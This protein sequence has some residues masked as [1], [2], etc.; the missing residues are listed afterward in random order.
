MVSLVAEITGYEGTKIVHAGG[1][2]LKLTA[3]DHDAP[4][5]YPA[6]TVI[7]IMINNDGETVSGFV[8][9]NAA[10]IAEYRK[11]QHQVSHEKTLDP[12]DPANIR[13]ELARQKSAADGKAR[14]TT[15]DPAKN[16]DPV[17]SRIEKPPSDIKTDRDP[18]EMTDHQPP[19]EQ[20]TAQ[21]VS[22]N[23]EIITISKSGSDTDRITYA[24]APSLYQRWMQITDVP[25]R[26][27]RWFFI[28]LDAR[29]VVAEAVPV[30]SPIAPTTEPAAA[31]PDTT[32]VFQTGAE[33]LAQNS[34]AAEP[35][36]IA[37]F[38]TLLLE[39]KRPGVPELIAWLESTDFFVAPGST[40]FH[41][42]ELGGLLQHSLQV[43]QNLQV[44]N[45]LFEGDY[46]EESLRIIAL[47]HDICKANFYQLSKKS[48][49]RRKADGDLDLDP[50]GKK[51]WDEQLVYEVQDREPLGHGEKSVM[52]IQRH[53]RLT[54]LEMYAIRWHMMSYDDLHYSYAGNVAITA[55][56]AK[57]PIIPLVHMADMS[58]SFLA[59]RKGSL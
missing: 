23:E 59:L 56:S 40:H 22:Y 38:K 26:E 24:I 48:L 34:V 15:A 9:L 18:R 25:T 5:K 54:D 14:V 55:A 52:L 41:N 44:L 12:E 36:Q 11:N 31:A 57:Y 1:K 2:D 10:Q 17:A 45:R 6:G 51:Q 58:A 29:Q 28:T 53:L 32:P 50:Y 4:L 49:P 27:G 35:D 39:T 47:L 43:Y 37:F 13:T 20:F 3:Y 46:P 30:N 33:I 21:L 7:K 42:A 19:L 8:A 16:P